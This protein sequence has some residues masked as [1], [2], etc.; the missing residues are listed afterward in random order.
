[1]GDGERNEKVSWLTLIT[2]CLTKRP[3]SA[4]SGQA[5]GP[6]ATHHLHGRVDSPLGSS[7]DGTGDSGDWRRSVVNQF[8]RKMH[9]LQVRSAFLTED[10]N[11]PFNLE[12]TLL[13][14]LP[15][16]LLLDLPLGPDLSALLSIHL[17]HEELEHAVPV[18]DIA[19]S[20]PAKQLVG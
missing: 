17:A 14:R 6:S 9:V 18:D 4:L 3:R 2:P 15:R 1:M 8:F 19:R 13:R 20:K 16:M 7:S 12:E 11:R 10:A 5:G